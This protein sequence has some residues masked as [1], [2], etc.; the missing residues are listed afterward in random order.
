M[1]N[2]STTLVLEPGADLGIKLQKRLQKRPSLTYSI[3]SFNHSARI[4]LFLRFRGN[5]PRKMVPHLL[6]GISFQKSCGICSSAGTMQQRIQGGR[7]NAKKRGGDEEEFGADPDADELGEEEPPLKKP[8][9]KKHSR[10]KKE[11]PGHDS[12]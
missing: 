3:I 9:P 1:G 2:G 11:L 4:I 6:V 10:V 7:R 12:P 8:V 5:S